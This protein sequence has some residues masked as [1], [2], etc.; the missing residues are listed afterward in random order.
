MESPMVALECPKCG[1][2]L[3]VTP[4]LETFACGH[5]GAS[6]RVRR[7]GGTISIERIEARLSNLERNTDRTAAELAIVRHEKDL[8]RIEDE[9]SVSGAANSTKVGAGFGCGAILAILGLLMLSGS[10]GRNQTGYLLW[11]LGL[12]AA[13]I[14]FRALQDESAAPLRKQRDELRRTIND[15]RTIADG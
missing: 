1:A 2:R 8:A 6:V 14:G 12:V 15:L 13:I 9:L 10:D 7:S 4:D 11:G 5:C 3:E